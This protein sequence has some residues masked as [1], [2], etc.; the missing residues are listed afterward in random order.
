M[1]EKNWNKIDDNIVRFEKVG[2]TVEGTL[3]SREQ[4][5]VYNN[6]VYHIKDKDKVNVVFGTTVLSSK[7]ASVG[8][9]DDV[10]IIFTG[11]QPNKKA[12][13]ND[14]KLFDVYTR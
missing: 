13:Q 6:E 12:G 10:K 5:T 2:D 14:I 7:M 3:V 9:G 1:T 4:S 8:I 11:T